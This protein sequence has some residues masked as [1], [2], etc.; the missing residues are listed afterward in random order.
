MT[1]RTPEPWETRA[2]A[3]ALTIRVDNKPVHVV[4]GTR[5]GVAIWRVVYGPFTTRDEAERA[6]RKTGLPFWVYEDAP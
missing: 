6:G 4:K 5:D 2:K 1:D 3:L